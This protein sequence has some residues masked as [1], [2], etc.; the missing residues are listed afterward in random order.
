MATSTIG[1]DELVARENAY[2]FIKSEVTRLDEDID[3]LIKHRLQIRGEL[4]RQER[5]FL[6]N[7][8]DIPNPKCPWT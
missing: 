6:D 1:M 5:W 3:R 2:L 7:K 4:V 8:L